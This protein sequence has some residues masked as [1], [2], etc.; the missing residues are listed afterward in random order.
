[1][2]EFT[3]NEKQELLEGMVKKVLRLYKRMLFKKYAK[4]DDV[5]ITKLGDKRI[6]GKVGEYYFY[7]DEYG[8]ITFENEKLEIKERS[9]CFTDP[10]GEVQHGT[11]QDGYTICGQVQLERGGKAR[12][13]NFDSNYKYKNLSMLMLKDKTNHPL[14]ACLHESFTTWKSEYGDRWLAGTLSGSVKYLL[15][16]AKE[17][18]EEK[19]SK[20]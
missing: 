6:C 11:E 15:A 14:D 8:T 5:E 16:K 20:K 1:M 10:E 7:C 9:T 3:E 18:K 2:K 13:L 17:K 4:E 19:S 12:I